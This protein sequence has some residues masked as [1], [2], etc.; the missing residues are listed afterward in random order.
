MFPLSDALKRRVRM[1]EAHSDD[2]E[3]EEKDD[4][5]ADD[6]E[7]EFEGYVIPQPRLHVT[8]DGR[9]EDRLLVRTEG[10]M[11]KKGGAV[12]QR[13]GR[14][15]WKKRWFVL[16]PFDFLGQDAYELQYF[17][18]PGGTLKG[19]VG[20]SDVVIFCE[21]RTKHH[22]IKYEFQLNLPNGGTLELSCDDA[23]EREEWIETINMVIA[24]MRT[25]THPAAM[26]LNG[27][28][29]LDEEDQEIFQMGEEIAANCQA[30]GPGLYGSE[31]GKR[32]QFVLQ[33]YDVM[34][35]QVSRGGMPV[36]CTIS[37]DEALYY[38]KV[39][40]ALVEAHVKFWHAV[41]M[42]NLPE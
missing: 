32:E 21:A 22:K 29:P 14:K 7:N 41:K 13:G 15:N 9:L 20:L 10:W 40:Q 37:N 6:E 3:D 2:G 19:S 31:A 35:Q 8:H 28:D 27:Y 36:T 25:L 33:V 30:Y 11:Y 18:K 4:V 38:V 24:F 39:C 17:D 34:G 26:V 42:P 1:V 16:A 5:A 12:N 23:T